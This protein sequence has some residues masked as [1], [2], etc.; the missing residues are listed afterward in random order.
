MNTQIRY[1]LL[2]QLLQSHNSFQ[3]II[4]EWKTI[5]GEGQLCSSGWLHC[6]TDPL[7]AVIFNPIH[8]HITNPLLFKCEVKGKTKTDH[9]LKEGWSEMRITEQIDVPVITNIQKIAFSILCAL[10]VYKEEKFV[11]WANNWLN[12]I[13]RSSESANSAAYAAN[14]AAAD[15]AYA[16]ANINLIEIAEKA[17]KY[18]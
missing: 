13:D 2:T 15:A 12:N 10:E 16:D 17:M 7:L 18:K 1:K 6:Y 4:N 3:W 14:N 9:G 5:S 8:A 11:L